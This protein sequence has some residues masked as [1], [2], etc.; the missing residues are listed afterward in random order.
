[1]LVGYQPTKAAVG[2]VKN[3]FN[4]LAEIG[5]EM[6]PVGNLNGSWRSGSNPTAIFTRTIAGHNLNPRM[7]TQPGF[8]G[9]SGAIREEI[10]NT[11]VLEI[12]KNRSVAVATAKSEV[13]DT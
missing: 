4:R 12:D 6:P 8:E 7:G 2:A 11:V 5:D 10:D 9:C 3:A 13:I 1:M